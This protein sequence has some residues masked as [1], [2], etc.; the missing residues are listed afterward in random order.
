M[1]MKFVVTAIVAIWLATSP[2]FAQSPSETLQRAIFAQ[3]AQGNIDDAIQGYRQVADSAA[4]PRDVAA[5]A[6]YRLSQALLLKGDLPSARQELERLEKGFP[7]Y[8]SL[9]AG[10]TESVKKAS[11][12]E[13]RAGTLPDGDVSFAVSSMVAEIAERDTD[14]GSRVTLRATVRSFFHGAEVFVMVEAEG[15]RYAL[16]LGTFD[17]MAATGP[18][19]RT[20]RF[21]SRETVTVEARHPFAQIVSADGVVVLRAQTITRAD[22]TI[23]FQR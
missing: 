11:P 21:K 14:Y 2:A 1:K 23:A 18:V 22:G 4:A 15:R 16:V 12:G 6:R 17:T 7:E 13:A 8:R 3:D 9:I 5:H 20:P 19:S 10:L